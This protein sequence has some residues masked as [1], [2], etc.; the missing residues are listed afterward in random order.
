[1]AQYKRLDISTPE[2]GVA[3]LNEH[4]KQGW[5][6]VAVVSQFNAIVAFLKKK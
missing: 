5:E 3:L 1:M 6:L 4:D 2:E